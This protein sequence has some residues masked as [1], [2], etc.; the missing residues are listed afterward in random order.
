MGVWTDLL[1]NPTIIVLALTLGTLGEIAKRVIKAKAGDRGWRGVYYVTLPAH[2][3][4]AGLL[5]GLAAGCAA[6]AGYPVLPIPDGLSKE[7]FEFA[8]ALGTGT[9]AGVVCKVGYDGIV[10]TAKRL[11][12]QPAARASSP[13]P[14]AG[15]GEEP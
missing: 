9:L 13:P 5:I 3:V 8:G 14:G 15:A 7:G 12:G 4:L 11:L 10:A 1:A 2:P 6:L